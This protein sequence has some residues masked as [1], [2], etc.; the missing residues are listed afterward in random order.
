MPGAW[1]RSA[2]LYAGAHFSGQVATG[3]NAQ[4]PAVHACDWHSEGNVQAAPFAFWGLQVLVP[5]RSQ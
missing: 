5:R 2:A 1:Q 3:P 4:T